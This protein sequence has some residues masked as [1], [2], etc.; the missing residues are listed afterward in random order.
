MAGRCA[1]IDDAAG[2]VVDDDVD[3]FRLMAHGA[4]HV[5]DGAPIAGGNRRCHVRGEIRCQLLATSLQGFARQGRHRTTGQRAH[6]GMHGLLFPPK[7]AGR[8]EQQHEQRRQHAEQLTAQAGPEVH[9]H[10]EF[11][12]SKSELKPNRSA[13]RRSW[14]MDPAS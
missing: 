2:G 6:L 5:F 10:Q 12:A 3:D 14:L 9:R 7:H 13:R 1:V 4:R 11:S 8:G